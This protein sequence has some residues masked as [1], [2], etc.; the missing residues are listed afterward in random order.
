[1]GGLG[2]TTLAQAAFNDERMKIHF[3]PRIWIH[4]S[5]DFN[6]KRVIKLIIES[7]SGGPY[8]VS[9][10]NLAQRKLREMLNGKRYLIVLDDV[11]DEDKEK[12]D[13]LKCILAR[14]SKGSSVIVTT[15]VE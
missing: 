3:S 5:E 7:I 12:W 2:E 9:D 15:H 6:L 1:M 4:V 14:G 11:W 10:L 13:K 8:Q